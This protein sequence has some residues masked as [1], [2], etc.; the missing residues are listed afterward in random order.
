METKVKKGGEHFFQIHTD[1]NRDLGIFLIFFGVIASAPLYYLASIAVNQPTYDLRPAIWIGLVFVIT[2]FYL[3]FF[4]KKSFWVS[5]N[6]IIIK[7]SF[8]KKRM[9]YD[10]SGSDKL[11]RLK[12]YEIEFKTTPVEIWEVFLAYGK[13]EFT[14]HKRP[15]SQLE[16]RQLAET[17]AK[18]LECPFEDLTFEEEGVTINPTD[19]DLPYKDRIL[20]YPQLLGKTAKEPAKV[21]F[22]VKDINNNRVFSWGIM[23]ARLLSDIL[24]LSALILLLSFIPIANNIPC[25]FKVCTEKNDFLVYYLFASLIS[26]S[27]VILSGY[28]V[29]L[30]LTPKNIE[31]TEYMWAFPYYHSSIDTNKIE[32][33]NMYVTLR[34]AKVQIIS[35]EKLIDIHLYN[36]ENARYLVYLIRKYLLT[37]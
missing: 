32:E 30:V 8:F 17:L 29:K 9:V 15:N 36:P 3:M 7:D 11:I 28:R 13:K 5:K 34:G 35:D 21:Y 4:S 2:G 27:I 19:L 23:T 33:I 16:M 1:T 6:K 10:C 22:K 31:F 12:N 26:I 24:F 20:K 14:I 37:V 18:I 25:F